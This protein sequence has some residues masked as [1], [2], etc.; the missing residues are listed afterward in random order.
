[1]GRDFGGM[2]RRR[3]GQRDGGGRSPRPRRDREGGG[4]HERVHSEREITFEMHTRLEMFFNSDE[5]ELA[6]EPMNSFKRRVAHTVAKTFGMES[7]S[8]GEEGDRHVFLR[9]TAE[10]RIPD[11]RPEA[12]EEESEAAYEEPDSEVDASPGNEMEAER[13]T[14]AERPRERGFDRDRGRDRERGGRGERNERG[15]SRAW[16]YGTQSFSVNP[17][18][19]GA[20]IVLKRDGSVELF[21]EEEKEYVLE[22]RLVTSRQFR[23]RNGK[24]LQPGEPG[25]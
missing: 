22:E 8:R 2:R 17:G 9:K 12:P 1:M 6:L 10:T 13:E 11:E 7:E 3:G 25:Y 5:Q 16:D 23:V 14:P 19:S 15:S 4:G 18:T 21:R 20:R 24:I